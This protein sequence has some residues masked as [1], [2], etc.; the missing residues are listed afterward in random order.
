MAAPAGGLSPAG[1]ATTFQL[2]P[3]TMRDLV[4]WHTL[5]RRPLP[6]AT[7][8]ADLLRQVAVLPPD[9]RWPFVGRLDT[10]ATHADPAVRAAAARALE[11]FDGR[12][13]F[14]LL[15]ELLHDDDRDVRQAALDALRVSCADDPARWAHALF[16]ADPDIRRA[17][18]D[19][20]R[21][22]PPPEWW[23]V[24]LLA[25]PETAALARRRLTG[26]ELPTTALPPLFDL[27]ARGTVDRDTLAGLTAGLSW[28]RWREFLA[29]S[30]PQSIEQALTPLANAW[31]ADDP[32]TWL[33]ETNRDV[34]D[35]VAD[36]YWTDTPARTADDPGS[37]F[38][39][40]LRAELPGMNDAWRLWFVLTFVVA[41]VRHGRWDPRAAG[42]V[43]V[44]QPEFLRCRWVPL[45]V[46]RRALDALTVAGE[47][48]PKAEPELVRALVTGDV[49]RDDDGRPDLAAVAAVLRLLP[50]RPLRQAREWL[51]AERLR[52]TFHADPERGAALFALEDRSDRGRADLLRDLGLTAVTGRARL[53][54]VL[55][56][57]VPVSGL[58]CLDPLDGRG[59]VEVFSEL[60]P[61]EAAGPRFSDARLRAL[62][63]LLAGKLGP[64]H[65]REFV[66]A[67]LTRA[68]PEASAL[69]L[70]LLARLARA[71]APGRVAAVAAELPP[72][73]LARFLTAVTWCAG[74]PPA[75]ERRLAEVLREHP[76]GEARTWSAARLPAAADAARTGT[77]ASP[78]VSAALDGPRKLGLCAALRREPDPPAP[79]P[80]VCVCL[81]A[82][83]DPLPDVDEQFARFA[84]TDPSALDAD[85]VSALR[86]DTTLPPWG[87]AWMHRWDAHAAAYARHL[88][89]RDGGAIGELSTAAALRSAALR[90]RVWEAVR[91][92]L[93]LWR[94]HDPLRLGDAVVGGLPAFLVDHLTGPEGDIAAAALMRLAATADLSALR[95]RVVAVSPQLTEETRRLLAG[96]VDLRGLVAPPA[97]PAD[98]PS[99]DQVGACDDVDELAAWCRSTDEGTALR[100]AL[101]LSRLGAPGRH[102]LAA[103]IA[104]APPQAGALAE[105][106]DDWP[107]GPARDALRATVL[108]A[109][110]P[111]AARYHAGVALLR[112]GEAGLLDT[113]AV[114]AADPGAND[115]FRPGD[116]ARI[117][118]SDT[119]EAELAVA[120]APATPP[121]LHVRAVDRLLSGSLPLPPETVD[122]ALFAFLDAGTERVAELRLRAARHLAGR[123][124][125]AEVLPVL[126]PSC[127]E[128]AGQPPDMLAGCDPRTLLAVAEAAVTSGRGH[129]LEQNLLTLLLAR[130]VDPYGR[131]EA[132]AT[133]LLGALSD[134]V[135][136]EARKHA[137]PSVTRA[138]KLRQVGEAFAWGVRVGRELTGKLFGVEMIPGEQLGYT[139]FGENKVFITPRPILRADRHGRDVV[140]A[141]ILHEFGH[142]MYHRDEEGLATWKRAEKE[143]LHGLLNLVSDEHLERNLRALDRSFG[144]RLKLLAAYAFQ[145]TARDFEVET[146]LDLLKGAAFAVLSGTRLTAARKSAS[147]G[148]ESGR[149]LQAMEKAGLSFPRFVRALRMGLGDRHDDEKVRRG[150]ELFRG[151]FRGST[152]P[153]LYDITLKLR[154]I[155]G[156][157]AKLIESL[158][159]DTLVVLDGD[160]LDLDGEGITPEEIDEATRRV[161]DGRRWRERASDDAVGGRRGVN[162]N[163][164]ERFDLIT[165]VQPV[166]YDPAAHARL[167]REVA[168]PARELRRYLEH[169]GLAAEP[170]RLRVRG[171]AFD[172]T[173][174]R[175][176]VLRGDPRM[177]IAREVQSFTDLFMAIVVDCSGSMQ[178]GANI[179]KARLFAAL[180]AEAAAGLRGVDVRV[181]GFTDK[182]IYDAGTASRCAA[183]GLEAK[184]GN[185][186]AAGLWHAALAAKASRRKAKLL[187]MISDGA[188]TECTVAAL[189]GLVNR[190][191]R[192]W[193]MCCAQVGVCELEHRCFP[194]Y[195]LLDSSDHVAS[196]RE[197]GRVVAKLVGKALGRG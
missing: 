32:Q 37:R 106:V 61:R 149:L 190:L 30:Q 96:W 98:V 69:G 59:A 157:E 6:P 132:L 47:A 46:R 134:T 104:G 24:Y 73:A 50:S 86:Q 22:F 107:P 5:A 10:H 179:E 153:Q 25:D 9:R 188:P 130:G 36:L 87:L 74:F 20:A 52:E 70:A 21:P 117:W 124:R 196:A 79:E 169:L 175:A 148:V 155:F 138:R 60:L 7:R 19:P 171:R 83:H 185:N 78:D 34:L 2:R 4:V 126:L 80:G 89:G 16:H 146:L 197:F 1:A 26:L 127:T 31:A 48:C 170:Q 111:A 13:A 139:R 63:D 172:R 42:L 182:V 85:A 150:L 162:L 57:T 82:C 66:G 12:P 8:L 40:G 45:P 192:R 15:V 113:I 143:G 23:A 64:G 160:E 17:A 120:F 137:R 110:T 121:G 18:I 142:H 178:H 145:H 125:A 92:A 118:E 184:G 144:D 55:A 54:A 93:D 99:S 14:A 44:Y 76:D 29:A 62:A 131:D 123:G 71:A 195:V 173:R 58:D 156:D 168:R 43:A 183:H 177:L 176:V 28:A 161:L 180:L 41:G 128:A 114:A 191:A 109:A 141:L 75:E 158:G 95:P 88:A 165:K 194:H 189:S 115:W 151:R 11:G 91:R 100:A 122:A 166:A 135:R 94:W 193:K 186:D 152:M 181:F 159:Q 129:E 163:A 174:A 49:C 68:R 77:L 84:D 136:T 108:D 72:A 119:P 147:V 164:E 27:A 101:R 187:V 81:L 35:T 105:A 112:V 65:L 33:A 154:E 167:A 97:P 90:R 38:F 3:H 103:V 116:A 140:Q 56:A 67:W 51:G 39:A 133:I 53:M 102:R